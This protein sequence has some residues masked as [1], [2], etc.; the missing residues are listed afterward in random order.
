M[1][2]KYISTRGGVEPIDFTSAVMMGLADDGGLLIPE[3]IPDVRGRLAQWRTLS[4]PELAYELMSLY[5]GD[6]ID[7]AALKGI[8][9]RSY[10]TFAAADVIPVK[11]VGK[12]NI[13]ELFH[14]PTLAF[15][16]VALQFLG[17]VFEHILAKSGDKLN[18]IGATSGD[19]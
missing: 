12:I 19:T 13:C 18:I 2:C 7:A 16:D 15:K 4:Y 17:N 10:A 8:V 1:K 5:V 11:P 6:T 14:G 9:Q 3:T